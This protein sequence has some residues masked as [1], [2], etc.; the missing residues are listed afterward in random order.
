VATTKDNKKERI[1]SDS[2][3]DKSNTED[4]TTS[5]TKDRRLADK[6]ND[7]EENSEEMEEEVGIIS[8]GWDMIIINIDKSY[9]NNI[10]KL[11]L[12]LDHHFK[13]I[14]IKKTKITANNNLIINFEDRDSYEQV[15]TS[16]ILF[17]DNKKFKLETKK[18]SSKKYYEAVI[19]GISIN[20]AKDCKAE[21]E[22]VGIEA[23]NNFN[24]NDEYKIIKVQF[25]NEQSMN[26][27]IND[28]LLLWYN[29]FKVEKYIQPIKPIQCFNCQ[30]FGH[31]SAKCEVKTSICVKCGGTHKLAD[32]QSDQIKCANC[33]E[34]HTSS[35]AGCKIFQK[36]VKEKIEHIKKKADSHVGNRQFSQ[37][38]KSNQSSS[39]S[40]SINEAIGRLDVAIQDMNKNFTKLIEENI[41]QVLIN[42]ENIFKRHLDSAYEN[43]EKRIEDKFV[44]G[45]KHSKEELKNYTT[46]QLD[47][48]NEQ[49]YKYKTNM[50]FVQIDLLRMMNP[51]FKPND[52]HLSFLIQTHWSHSGIEIDINKLKSYV[53]KSYVQ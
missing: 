50:V 13:N 9:S 14:K 49:F 35:Y 1:R 37:I 28:G 21:L 31:F 52:D 43:L 11:K 53:D 29:K 47:A 8:N 39:E 44:E 19:K 32:C 34:N 48:L 17:K 4:Q 12:D 38:V 45:I 42:Q 2:L 16:K 22:N 26:K 46:K 7:G 33:K 41:Q 36:Q 3:E 27:V 20:M 10:R 15:L 23:V 24:K 51:K 5:Y 30:K 40:N 6:M 18:K 25:S